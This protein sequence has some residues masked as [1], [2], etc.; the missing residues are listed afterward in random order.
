MS[1]IWGFVSVPPRGVT[2]DFP[3]GGT[4]PCQSF[5]LAVVCFSSLTSSRLRLPAGFW[6]GVFLGSAELLLIAS[7]SDRPSSDFKTLFQ[8]IFFMQTCVSPA[9]VSLPEAASPVSMSLDECGGFVPG[10]PWAGGCQRAGLA[11]QEPGVGLTAPGSA[12]AGRAIPPFGSLQL[13]ADFTP[14]FRNP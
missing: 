2:A 12:V 9:E 8:I 4:G 6:P 3:R 1:G 14:E 10:W 11:A 5:L 13:E 7:A